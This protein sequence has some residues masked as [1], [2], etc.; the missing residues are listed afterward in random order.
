LFFGRFLPR[1]K[2]EGP[3]HLS[4]RKVLK[5]ELKKAQ[6]CQKKEF[7]PLTLGGGRPNKIVFY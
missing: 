5:K 6:E 7:R 2:T 3:P 1:G 4:V